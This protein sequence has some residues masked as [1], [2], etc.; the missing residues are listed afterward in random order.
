MLVSGIEKVY[1]FG[2]KLSKLLPREESIRNYRN[3]DCWETASQNPVFWIF[4]LKNENYIWGCTYNQINTGI[5]SY[6][7]ETNRSR[8]THELKRC[9]M[10]NFEFFKSTYRILDTRDQEDKFGILFQPNYSEFG[11]TK[12]TLVFYTL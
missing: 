12:D 7:L 5:T 11:C 8:M 6:N 9:G 3:F 1:N 2:T 10:S 4:F